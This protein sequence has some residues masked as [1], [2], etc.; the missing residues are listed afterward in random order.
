LTY[1][2]NPQRELEA[3]RKG[4]VGEDGEEDEE[5]ENAPKQTPKKTD[6]TS[7]AAKRKA[8]EES[9]AKLMMGKKDKRLYDKIKFGE[10]RKAARVS[11]LEAKRA[12][13]K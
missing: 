6:A 5:Q 1:A 13:T 3:E 4:A 9:R 11:E 2:R 8:E 7:R 10:A 12:K